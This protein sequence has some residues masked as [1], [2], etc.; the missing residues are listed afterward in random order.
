MT[1][2]PQINTLVTVR[3]EG[4]DTLYRSRIEGADERALAIALPSDGLT[5]HRLANR[6]LVGVEWCV[7]RGLGSVEGIVAG[8]TDL[9]VPALVI[10]LL[11]QPILF[12]RREHARA[13]VV[14]D[15]EIWPDPE[16][17]EPVAGVT[18]DVSGGG[19]RAV[20]PA[21]VEAGQ[22][23]RFLVNMPDGRTVNGLARVVAQR[24]DDI[25]AL[26]FNEIVQADRERLIRT[27]FASYQGPAARRER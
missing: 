4:S 26:E 6:T 11:S 14:L 27:V 2:L 10:E 19:L 20:I 18:L 22:L 1:P 23:V 13:D 17:E 8:H 25:V 12:Q 16:D 7:G 24:D 3:V 5:E 15:I 9:G 21:D